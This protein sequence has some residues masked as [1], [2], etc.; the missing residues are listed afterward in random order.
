MEEYVS[1]FEE[2][3][4]D[5]FDHIINISSVDCKEMLDAVGITK[6]GSSGVWA[7]KDQAWYSRVTLE[8]WSGNLCGR[9]AR[10]HSLMQPFLEAGKTRNMHKEAVILL[11]TI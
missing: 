1:A 2:N 11:G 10:S 7:V 6:L 3:G 8:I 5:D 4:F 9:M